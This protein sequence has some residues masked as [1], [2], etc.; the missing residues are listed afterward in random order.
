[1]L[2]SNLLEHIVLKDKNEFYK[3]VTHLTMVKIFSHPCFTE[4]FANQ[5][6]FRKLE[7]KFLYGASVKI[8]IIVLPFFKF[9]VY[10]LNVGSKP[11]IKMF[12]KVD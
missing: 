8:Y 1:M 11:K 2:L 10:I 9:Q 3:S 12:L 5:P 4:F 6:R 7:E